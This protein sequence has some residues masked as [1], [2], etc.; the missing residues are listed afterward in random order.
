MLG[1]ICI[2][3]IE[4]IKKSTKGKFKGWVF[5]P[6]VHHEDSNI[7]HGGL[8]P[9]RDAPNNVSPFDFYAKNP[10]TKSKTFIKVKVPGRPLRLICLSFVPPDTVKSTNLTKPVVYLTFWRANGWVCH[11]FRA[12]R[13][14]KYA[15]RD[16]CP[17]GYHNLLTYGICRV[18]KPSRKK[19]KIIHTYEIDFSLPESSLE[20]AA[21]SLRLLEK[22]YVWRGRKS[23]S[24]VGHLPFY[25]IDLDGENYECDEYQ[26]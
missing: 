13:F 25:L 3:F 14:M 1:A 15:P 4:A 24:F 11:D 21:Q 10:P 12:K 9:V 22:S 2:D 20:T 26:L 5:T 19:R 16:E 7:S 8:L 6:L 23:E 17:D 18:S